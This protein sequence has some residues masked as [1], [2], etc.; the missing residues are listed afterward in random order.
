MEMEMIF[1]SSNYGYWVNPVLGRA[2]IGWGRTKRSPKNPFPS[3]KQGN[4]EEHFTEVN[5]RLITA[6]YK[7]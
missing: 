1:V 4:D 7:I 2:P 3:D 6:Q 5:P